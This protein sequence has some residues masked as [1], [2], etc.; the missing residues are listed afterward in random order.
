MAAGTPAITSVSSHLEKGRTGEQESLMP[1]VSLPP[2]LLSW[3]LHSQLPLVS[4]WPP[5]TQGRQHNTLFLTLTIL[6]CESREF[7][8][9]LCFIIHACVRLFMTISS[10]RAEHT[11]LI[12]ALAPGDEASVPSPDHY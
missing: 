12:C 1:L 5:L 9:H 7:F 3:E 4:P 11:A 10:L 8:P 6:I 2:N